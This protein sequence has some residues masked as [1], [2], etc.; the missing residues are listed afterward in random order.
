MAS[1]L[2]F[3]GDLFVKSSYSLERL[4]FAFVALVINAEN[5]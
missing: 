1:D 2:D 4:A 5:K 3:Y